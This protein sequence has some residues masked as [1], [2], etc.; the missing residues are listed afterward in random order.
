MKLNWQQ[1]LPKKETFK[2]KALSYVFSSAAV[3]VGAYSLY[4]YDT[5]NFFS[6]AEDQYK[7][8]AGGVISAV[9]AIAGIL[10]G[11]K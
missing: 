4:L 2:M 1:S 10:I 8:F 6:T 11:R 3:I 9:F 5:L 7:V